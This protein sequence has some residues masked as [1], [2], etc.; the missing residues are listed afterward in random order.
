MKNSKHS[1]IQYIVNTINKG[2]NNPSDQKKHLEGKDRIT[3]YRL[4]YYDKYTLEF[5]KQKKG[6]L[7]RLSGYTVCDTMHKSEQKI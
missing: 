6:D 5:F 1:D 2:I 4:D 7:I 3:L